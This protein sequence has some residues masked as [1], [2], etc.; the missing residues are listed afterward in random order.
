MT[1]LVKFTAAAGTPR[2]EIAD[3]LGPD[4]DVWKAGP[5]WMVVRLEMDKADVPQADGVTS[6]ILCDHLEDRIAAGSVCG[7]EAYHSADRLAADMRALA[8]A[9]PDICTLEEIGRSVENRPIL[10]LRIGADDDATRNAGLVIGCHHAREWISVEVPYLLAEHMVR[11]REEPFVASLLANGATWIVPMLNPDGHEFSRTQ[12]RFWR[13]NRRANSDGSFGVDLNR[14]YGVGWDT[15]GAGTVTVPRSDQYR[16]P[17]ALS[18][19]ETAAIAALFERRIAASGRPFA[20]ILTYHSFSQVILHPWSHTRA[21]IGGADGQ[22]I[23]QIGADMQTRL[24]G[25]GDAVYGLSKGSE[26]GQVGGVTG[27]WAYETHGTF[28]FTIELPPEADS[29]VGF[30][31]PADEIAPVARQ[32]L[33]AAMHYLKELFALRQTNGLA[34]AK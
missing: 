23:R 33:P 10:A 16:G 34:M 24:N 32:A 17:A 21:A 31:L 8:E 15:P 2:A 7:P 30:L 3:M 19:P 27:D 25:A 4:A 12:N 20:G 6:E 26:F 1:L 11:R 5:D 18:E 22:F 29:E 14:N 13:K 9:A 28:C